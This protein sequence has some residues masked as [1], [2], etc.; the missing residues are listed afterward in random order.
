MRA[1]MMTPLFLAACVGAEGSTAPPRPQRMPVVWECECDADA[2]AGE[3]METCSA[4]DIVR[5][6]GCECTST[7]ERCEK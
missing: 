1:L 5:A 2:D 6:A 3:D 7:G 4:R